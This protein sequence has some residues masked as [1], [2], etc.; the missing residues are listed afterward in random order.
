[1]KGLRVGN[2][3]QSMVCLMIVSAIILAGITIAGGLL[4]EQAMV[5]DFSRKNLTPSAVPVWY[6]LDGERHVCENADRPF[7]EYSAGAF[8]SGSQFGGS[9][10]DGNRGGIHGTVCRW[11][12]KRPD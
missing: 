4:E 8:D 9:F 12:D 2:R 1:M 7:A 6:G 5:T 11:G 3:R 10:F